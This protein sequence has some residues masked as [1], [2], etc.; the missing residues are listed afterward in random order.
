MLEDTNIT[1]AIVV[2]DVFG[3]RG[4]RM[5]DALVAGERDPAKLSSRALGT[6]RRQIPQREVALQ[7]RFAA[8]HAQLLRGALELV[9]V[10]GRQIAEIEQQLQALLRSMALAVSRAT[11]FLF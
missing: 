6:L 11:L 3:K 7:G 2:S 10:L 8:H 9:E 1:R 4:R 5:L